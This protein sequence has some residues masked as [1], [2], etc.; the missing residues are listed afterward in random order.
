MIVFDLACEQGHVFE[1]WFGSSADYESQ[2]ERGL[3]SCAIC[4]AR[5]VSKAVMA[6]NVGAKGNRATAVL[7]MR[8][9]S[10]PPAELKAALAA[11]AKAQAKALEGS[12]H[13]GGRFGGE[14]RAIHDGD[15]PERAIH[16]QATAEEAKALVEDGVPVLPLPLPI[17]PP[18][19]TH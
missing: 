16:G 4:G 18:E 13:V 11:L 5:E 8:S 19:V 6:P 17:V 10:P 9:G 15:A 2:R 14:A 3:V 7:P 12:E 1:A